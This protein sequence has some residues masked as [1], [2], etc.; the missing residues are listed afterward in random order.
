MFCHIGY[1][2]PLARQLEAGATS[3]RCHHVTSP[4]GLNQ[5]HS[6]RHGTPPV[7]RKQ[8]AWLDTVEVDTTQHCARRSE[9]FRIQR[10]KPMPAL[11]RL[12]RV[13]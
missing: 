8:V 5:M 4:A 13:F 3:S 7:V 11:D 9:R 1:S 12:Q 2:E 10:P 6:L